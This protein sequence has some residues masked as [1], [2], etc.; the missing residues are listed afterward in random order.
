MYLAGWVSA[1][2]ILKEK[3]TK[4]ASENGLIFLSPIKNLYSMDNAAM[5]GIRAHYKIKMKMI[6]G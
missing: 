2:T 3:L 4:L 5:V 6:N 1:N